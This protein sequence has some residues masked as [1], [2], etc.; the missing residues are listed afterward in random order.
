MAEHAAHTRGRGTPAPSP[1]KSLRSP[2]GA[3]CQLPA[4]AGVYMTRQREAGARVLVRASNCL[5]KVARAQG[6]HLQAWM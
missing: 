1:L 5:F 6:C 2:G 4:P 3:G